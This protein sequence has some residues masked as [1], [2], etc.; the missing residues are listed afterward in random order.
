MSVSYQSNQ[1]WELWQSSTGR[2]CPGVWTN[3][4]NSDVSR[5]EGRWQWRELKKLWTWYWKRQRIGSLLNISLLW[6]PMKKKEKNMASPL[7]GHFSHPLE[8]S[9]AV[10][11][12][13]VLLVKV[14]RL[15]YW[16]A[17]WLGK[18]SFAFSFHW[19]NSYIMHTTS[20]LVFFCGL[21]TWSPENIWIWDDF[22]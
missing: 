18:A 7:Y 9:F 17:S 11:C 21:F 5:N 8:L 16:T 22:V 14:K 19:Y 1:W 2:Y 10:L 20:R 13:K 12:E 15:D 3:S 6:S 4:E